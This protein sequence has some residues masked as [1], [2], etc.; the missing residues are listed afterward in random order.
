L[1]RQRKNPKTGKTEWALV[2]HSGRVLEWFGV[3][4]P[5]KG[6]VDKA[7]ARVNYYKHKGK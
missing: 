4:K 5:S 2:S 1:L 3:K 6:R 7:E